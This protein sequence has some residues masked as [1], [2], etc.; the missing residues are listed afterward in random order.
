MDAHDYETP[1]EAALA[2]WPQRATPRVVRVEYSADASQATV[3]VTVNDKPPYPYY[4]HCALNEHGRWDE[5][6]SNN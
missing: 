6:S 1:Q 3:V 2:M 4:V 5:L